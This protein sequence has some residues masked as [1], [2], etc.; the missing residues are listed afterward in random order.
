MAK[1]LIRFDDI[2]PRMSWKKFNII[3]KF[4]EECNI[5]CILAVIPNNKDKNL[6]LE[7]PRKNFFQFLRS[8]KKYGDTIAQ[9]GFKHVYHTID[10]G[11]LKINKASEY[12]SL[13][14]KE[15]YKSISEGKKILN[16]QNLFQGIFVAPAHSYD[17]NTILA[18]KKLGFKIFSDGHSLYPFSYLKMYFI[19]QFN[20]FSFFPFG[21]I[22]LAIHCNTISKKK[23]EE[24][25]LFIGKNKHDF[26]DV[27][28]VIKQNPYEKKYQKLTRY[29]ITFTLPI[30]RKIRYFLK[31]LISR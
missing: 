15:Q 9:H 12:A 23:I 3:K 30:Y 20:F 7:K 17:N 19:P 4:L 11:I 29:I 1:Y 5:K 8:K 2:C 13:S 24:L 28:Y 27:D 25:I 18:A 26:V 10:G 31:N 21:Y 14:Y 22:T 6:N 16:K